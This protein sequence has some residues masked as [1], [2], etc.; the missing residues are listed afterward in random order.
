MKPRLLILLSTLLMTVY[1]V[2]SEPDAVTD[3]DVV[4]AEEMLRQPQYH[5]QATLTALLAPKP[6]LKGNV[7]FQLP[8]VPLATPKLV[9]V[10][11]VIAP[12]PPPPPQAPGLP[13]RF[14]GRIQ[15]DS[16]VRVFLQHGEDL[17]YA[18]EGQ[19]LSLDYQVVEIARNRVTFLYLPLNL[20]QELIINEQVP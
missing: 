4:V 9:A 16:G 7:L 3:T 10:A 11:P 1:V 5:H 18:A 12:P 6:A 19:K 17:F 8:V 15:D 2:V 14:L 20:Q 13:F